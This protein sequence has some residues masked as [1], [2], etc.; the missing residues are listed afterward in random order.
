MSPTQAQAALMQCAIESVPLLRAI[1]ISGVSTETIEH[2]I[3]DVPLPTIEEVF[4]EHSVIGKL[5]NGICTQLLVV[6]VSV[7]PSTNTVEVAMADPLDTHARQELAYHLEA[8]IVAIRAP[9]AAIDRALA[10]MSTPESDGAS[11]PVSSRDPNSETD[12]SVSFIP[13][14]SIPTRRVD[15][16]FG[17][18]GPALDVAEDHNPE[19]G[20]EHSVEQPP[21]QAIS[22][23]RMSSSFRDLSPA[24]LDSSVIKSIHV[25]IPSAPSLPTIQ[26]QSECELVSS[27]VELEVEDSLDDLDCATDRDGVVV[28]AI[29][30]MSCVAGRVGVFAARREYFAG[31][32]CSLSLAPIGVFRSIRITRDVDSVL[33]RAACDGWYFGFIPRDAIHEQLNA[34]LPHPGY[35]ATIVAVRIR[36]R[37]AMLILGT[38]LKDTVVAVRTAE[39]IAQ[40][41]TKALV[42]VL[43][44]EKR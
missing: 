27:E 12:P 29:R 22:V 33:S 3:S 42:R 24:S 16:P 7:D 1:H 21:S 39:R 10:D 6:P 43:R 25:V 32:A 38:Q 28:A 30:G 4:P 23:P 11:A 35:D 20:V 15:E 37:A 40:A 31:W 44:A 5:P 13:L 9:I 19:K 14:S 36:E 34:L 17:I 26:E 8:N 2:Q 18:N 41:S